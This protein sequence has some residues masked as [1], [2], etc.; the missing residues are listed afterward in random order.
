MEVIE[1]EV[2]EILLFVGML[3][4]EVWLFDE[5]VIGVVIWGDEFICLCGDMCIEKGDIVVFLVE[6]GMIEKVEK[7]FRV[8]L[9]YF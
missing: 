9:E 1:V 7:V 5:I 8:S 4:K 6:W 2:L 3:F